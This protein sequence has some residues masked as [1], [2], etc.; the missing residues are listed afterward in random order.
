[1]NNLSESALLET[2]RNTIHQESEA[3]HALEGMLTEDFG[4]TVR[5]IARSTGRVVVSGIGKSA[6]IAQKIVA[7]FNSTGTPALFMHAGDAIHGDLGMIR[8]EDVVIC[9]SKS[10]ESPEIKLLAPLVKNFHNPLIAIVGN[11]DSY[12]AQQADFILNTTVSQ[13]ACPNNLAPTAS[14]T[15]QLAMGDALAVCLMKLKGF[16]SDDFAKFHPGGTLGKKL[17]LKVKDLSLQNEKPAV[18]KETLMKEVIME[19]TKRRLGMTTVL[20]E[21]GKIAGIITDGDLRRMLK[22]RST[23]ETLRAADV[24]NTHPKTVSDEALAVHALEL[25]R[26]YNIT[27]LIVLNND[28]YSGVI[29]LHD[30][31]KEGLL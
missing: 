1:M 4:K 29:H 19:I 2:A 17:Y 12:L 9:I 24:M 21:G 30:I 10:G 23:W 31:I 3:L 5:L 13:E 26:R 25:M 22:E 7:T 8:Q 14:T 18:G 28:E 27:Q 6:I 15:A 11:V 20:D 16:S